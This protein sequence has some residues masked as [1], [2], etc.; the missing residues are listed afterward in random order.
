MIENPAERA[1]KQTKAQILAAKH[2][3]TLER[4]TITKDNAHINYAN[5]QISLAEAE[6]RYKKNPTYKT[7]RFW[8]TAL[9]NAL[10]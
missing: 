9:V 1:A 5:A 2:A 6:K 3:A 10:P 4:K 7:Y 8:Q